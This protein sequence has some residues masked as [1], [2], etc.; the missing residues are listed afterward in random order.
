MLATASSL[1]V[2]P[3]FLRYDLLIELSRLQLAIDGARHACANEHDAIADLET[4]RAAISD[5]LRRL[6]A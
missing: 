6:S 4:R 2:N 3:M 1:S 5:T